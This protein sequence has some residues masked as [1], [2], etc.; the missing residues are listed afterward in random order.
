MVRWVDRPATPQ[1]RLRRSSPR[2]SDVSPSAPSPRSDAID[3]QL[4]EDTLTA[5]T[6]SS[7]CQPADVGPL[8]VETAL[9]GSLNPLIAPLVGAGV[10]VSL[11]RL[12]I[13]GQ[14]MTT[15]PVEVEHQVEA[16]LERSVGR[17]LK[18]T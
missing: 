1:P 13:D 17:L 14:A 15:G 10:V 12:T 11:A 4:R 3:L 2:R 6:A 18:V 5:F 16:S 9:Y 7:G 8:W